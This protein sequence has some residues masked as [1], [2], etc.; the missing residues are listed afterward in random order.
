MQPDITTLEF[1]AW[2]IFWV[3]VGSLATIGGIVFARQIGV[4]QIHWAR[5]AFNLNMK[6]AQC[7]VGTRCR[8]SLQPFSPSRPDITRYEIVTS[9]YNAGDLAA[10]NLKGQW[11]V[12]CSDARYDCSVP[13]W[14][15]FVSKASPYELEPYIFA[16]TEITQSIRSCQARINV[17]FEFNFVGLDDENPIP[18]AAKYEYSHEAKQMVRIG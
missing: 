18:Y 10:C 1:S 17:D 7:N 13:V 4:L 3:A 11:K 9:I 5:E 12:S 8:L 6:L 14:I 2:S 16:S 15:D